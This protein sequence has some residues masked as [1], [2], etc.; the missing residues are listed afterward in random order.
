MLVS[1]LKPSS[2]HPLLPNVKPRP[3]LPLGLISYW[4]FLPVNREGASLFFLEM[5]GVGR[6]L[7]VAEN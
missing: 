7:D 6:K 2:P 1:T 4:L 3:V 5:V